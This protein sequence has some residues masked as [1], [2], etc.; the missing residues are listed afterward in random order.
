MTLNQAY[1]L[2]R[3]TAHRHGADTTPAMAPFAKD[4]REF[5]QFAQG[6]RDV[7]AEDRLNLCGEWDR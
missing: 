4:S 7:L 3:N 2:G 6:V 1:Y 5:A